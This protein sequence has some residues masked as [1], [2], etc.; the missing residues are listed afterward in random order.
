[1]ETLQRLLLA[2]TP[3]DA[4][5][6]AFFVAAWFGYNFFIDREM[7]NA[8]GLRALM[9]QHRLEWARQ[10]VVRDQRLLDTALM[11]HLMNSV[12][13]YANTTIYI[14]AALIAT[15]G[16]LD[17]LVSFAAELPFAGRQSKLLVEAK[18]FLLITI[19]VFA[20][21]KFTWAHRQYSLMLILIG[22]TP[23]R[24]RPPDALEAYAQ[25]CARINTFA[26]DE[27]NR[28]IRSYYFGFAALGWFLHTLVFMAL[29]LLILVVLWRRDYR[30]KT[31]RALAA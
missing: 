13:F 16:A 11:G 7:Q 21:F 24:S 25:K 30:S 17:S 31:T 6:L 26:G 10:M 9:H 1:M 23:D 14:V 28:G 19:F 8:R 5:A 29:T 15:A 20:Y 3:L 2:V 12:S 18:I 4:I 22:S 27:F